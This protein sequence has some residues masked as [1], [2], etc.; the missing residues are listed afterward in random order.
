MLGIVVVVVRRSMVFFCLFGYRI[1][2]RKCMDI[3]E[4]L[5]FVWKI[6]SIA[7]EPIRT[8]QI[9][10]INNNNN[11]NNNNTYTRI[12]KIKTNILIMRKQA[13]AC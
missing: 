3:G 5:P 6:N 2:F 12:Q 4:K 9:I 10:I 8:T 13:N 11:N 1:G 7:F